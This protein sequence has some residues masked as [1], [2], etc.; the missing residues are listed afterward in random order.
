VKLPNRKLTLVIFF[1]ILILIAIITTY[2]LHQTPEM[3]TIT[4]TAGTYTNTANYDYTASVNTSPIYGNK[5]TLKP[6]DGVLYTKLTNKIDLTLTYTF[7]S[8]LTANPTITYNIVTTLKTDAWQ[9]PLSTTPDTTTD[10]TTIQITLPT[11][12][13]GQIEQTKARIDNETGTTNFYSSTEPQYVLEITPAFT[14]T[15]ATEAGTINEDFQPTLTINSTR[16]TEGNILIINDLTQ[17]TTG[18][19]TQQQTITNPEITNQRYASYSL[20][21]ISAIGLTYSAFTLK[22][23]QPTQA[24]NPTKKLTEQYRDLIVEATQNTNAATTIN[25][26]NLAELAKTAEILARPIFHHATENEDTFY[27]IENNTKYQYKVTKNN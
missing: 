23:R 20:L 18:T 14:I 3:Q 10:Q 22:K 21:A 12:N 1:T 11:F 26:I 6:S 27:I 7:T 19:L 8:T 2:S 16:S 13:K 25:V 24:P 15:A 5:T 17:T 4:T 9:Y